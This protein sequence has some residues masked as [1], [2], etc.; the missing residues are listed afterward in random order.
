[1]GA[2]L[3]AQ[4]LGIRR[5][6]AMKV[7]LDLKQGEAPLRLHVKTAKCAEVTS[8]VLGGKKAPICVSTL[9]EAERFFEEGYAD[10]LYAVVDPRIKY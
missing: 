9:K 8:L 2:I 4:D 1:M 6:V 3:S 7:L 5:V 10:I